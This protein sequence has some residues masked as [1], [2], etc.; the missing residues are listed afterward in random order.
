[1]KRT[2]IIAVGSELLLGEITNTNARYL[3]EQLSKYGLSVLYH[4]VVGDNRERLKATL[5][6]AKSRSELV[7]VTGGLGPTADDI[8]KTTLADVLG[9]PLVRDEAS[10]ET[11]RRFVASRGRTMNEGDARQADVLSGSEVLDN[12]VGLAPGMWIEGETTWLLLPGVPWEMKAIVESTFPNKFTG[13]TI[14][15]ESLRFYE[16]GES[17][18]D[19]AVVDLTTGANPT[20]AP[21]AE[22]GEARLRIS[23]RAETESEAR[24]MVD[25]VKR[26]ILNRVGRY[27]FGSDEET[28]A[29]HL[30]RELQ[31]RNATL[32]IAESLTGGQAQAMLTAVPGASSVFKGGV[33]TYSDELKNRFLGVSLDTIES[34]SVVSKEVAFEMILGLIRQTDTDYGLAFTGEAGPTSSSGQPVGKV[35]IGIRSPAGIDVIERNYPHQERHVIQARATK[36]GIWA[37]LQQMKKGE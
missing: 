33:V 17:A 23:A 13:A 25:R 28:L 1:M 8:T 22:S 30:I 31:A 11:I 3:S 26:D 34:H 29:T 24:Q 16:I 37:L 9:R 35:F 4:V 32:S 20:V 27:Y 10:L 6:E 2:E 5:E 21:Y 36:D 19:E 7:I 12:P 14:H 15:S 18:L